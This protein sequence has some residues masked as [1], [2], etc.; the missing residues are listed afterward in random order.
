MTLID[1]PVVEETL[2]EEPLVEEQATAVEAGAAV[3][4]AAAGAPGTVGPPEEAWIPPPLIRPLLVASFSSAGAALMAGGIFGSWMARLL[5][6]ASA[7]LGIGWAWFVVRRPVRRLL[8]HALLL[9]LMVVGSIA[10]I[11]I[12]APSASPLSLMSKAIHS[13]RVLRPPVPF[14]PGWRPIIFVLFVTVGFAAGWL[15]TALGRTQAALVLPMPI[16]VLTA[17]T[18]P[19]EGE[20]LAG[21]LGLVPILAALAV[22]YGGE[23]AGLPRLGRDFELKRLIRGIALG[24]G[25]L[26]VLGLLSRSTV[27]FPKPAYNPAQKPQKPK[28]IPLSAAKDRVLFEVAGQDGGDPPISGPWIIGT[29]DVYD[30]ALWR[31]APVDPRRLKPLP[32]DNIVDK[33]HPPE[34]TIRFTT[35]DL[36]DTSTFPTTAMPIQGN[37]SGQSVVFDSRTQTFRVKAGR[38][39]VN[40]S[41]TIAMPKYPTGAQLQ[42][43]TNTVPKEMKEFVDIPPPPPAVRD[44]LNA[45][46]ANPWQRLD[47]LRSKLNQVV[48]ATGAGAPGPVPP[49]KVQELLAGNHEGTP[50]EI[51]AAEAMLARWAGVPARIGFGFDAGQKEGNATTLRPKNAAQFLE[52]WF[53]GYGWIP[54]IS[55]PPKAKTSLNTDKNQQFDPTIQPSDDV[56]VELVIPFQLESLTQL[57]QKVRNVVINAT[58]YVAAILLIFLLAPAFQKWRRRSKRRR[59]ALQHGVRE[60]IAVEY[61]EF[62]DLTTDLS[63]GHPYDTPLEFLDRTIDDAEHEEFAWLVTRVLYGD[64]GDDASPDDARAAI[65]MGESLRRRMFRAQPYQTRVLGFL[66]GASLSDPYSTEIPNVRP[67][68]L[69]RKRKQ[70]AGADGGRRRRR[71]QPWWKRALGRVRTLRP[72]IP[73]TRMGGKA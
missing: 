41:Y 36:G 33:T 68:R 57:Y 11:A 37:F 48:V 62:R 7:L 4:E 34:V 49:S 38:V 64:L 47:F 54:V 66:S 65:D 22:L 60:R 52:V 10:L 56:G 5:G 73:M 17:I 1:E 6:V 18:Q 20:L 46:P 45:A 71:R 3:T 58:P 24:V 12:D 30:G 15:G 51:V 59:W 70:S 67:V 19:A 26:V 44:L 23:N 55:Q 35:R 72:K 43:A 13:G 42:A 40:Y 31:L 29:L 9:P 16:L 32:G 2:A 27:L 25:V 69:R 61:A 39:P 8:K 53:N 21:F 63:L 14:D 50:F 28:A